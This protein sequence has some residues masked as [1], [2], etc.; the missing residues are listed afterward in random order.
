MN[1]SSF[2]YISDF[3]LSDI[4]GGGELNDHE[5]CS[6]L[7]A[8]KIRS[9]FVTLDFLSNHR[10]SNIIVSNY[11]N[12][13]QDCILELIKNHDYVIYEHDHKYLKNRNP[14]AYENY[15]APKSELVNVDFYK[16]ANAVFCQS[17]FH[18]NIIKKNIDITNVCNVSGNLWSVE[19]LRILDILSKKEK[20]DRYSILNSGTWHKNTS[21]TSF[22]CDKKGFKY[23]LISSSDYNEFL[24]LMSNNDKFIF[25]PKTP[26]TLS[27]VIVEAR[28]MGIKVITNKNVGA[29]YEPWFSLKGSD[30]INYMK[31][32]REEI[33]KLIME[34]F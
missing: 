33:P 11:I 26:E 7:G 3:F 4:V 6:I 32:K 17:T 24:S 1:K 21:E 16:N 27:R 29:S 15:Q 13:S 18:E 19:S 8:L 25:L 12:L 10:D 20:R 5:L 22:Y 30:L 9:Q 23:D 31:N 28:M 2:L 34:K 14:A